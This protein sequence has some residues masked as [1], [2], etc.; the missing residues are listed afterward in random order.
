MAKVLIVDEL[1]ANRE[2]LVTFLGNR[3]HQVIEATD[4][5]VALPLARAEHPD[6]IIADIL[7][8]TMD[9]S[10][11][12]QKLRLD[13]ALAATPVVFSSPDFL[14]REARALAD[15]CNVSFVLTKPC[16]ADDVLRAAELALDLPEASATHG[17]AAQSNGDHPSL[18]EDQLPQTREEL[19]AAN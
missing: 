11:L 8:P 13:P 18:L 19:K 14:A 2:L 16:Q 1:A 3:G 17:D 15:Q 6:L 9:G 5:S 12:V 10:E 7:T 4:G